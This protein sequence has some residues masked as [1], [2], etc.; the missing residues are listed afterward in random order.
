MMNMKFDMA[1]SATVS[2]SVFQAAVVAYGEMLYEKGRYAE[3]IERLVQASSLVNPDEHGARSTSVRFRLA[4]SYRQSANEI[5]VRL[6]TEGMPA[7]EQERLDL[8]RRERF[9]EAASRFSDLIDGLTRVDPSRL[10]PLER[11]YL[12]NSFFYR[13]D[14]SY[15]LALAS[16]GEERHRGF[17]EAIL[18]YEEALERYADD[19][20]ALVAMI[21]I[22]HCY[23]KRGS[24]GDVK[25]GGTVADRARRLY[26]T[27]DPAVL[28]DPTLPLAREDWERWLDSIET[29]SSI[30]NA[31]DT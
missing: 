13:G 2:S 17:T 6:E 5:R 26:A 25:R 4:D 31:G 24:E 9:R 20:A 15:E 14:C 30:A 18:S 22:T 23:L 10:T 16:A 3:A 1:G 11:V 7:H 27:M 12:R 19:P 8:L 29:L 28:N 21:Q